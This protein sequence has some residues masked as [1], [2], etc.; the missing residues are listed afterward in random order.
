[1]E[2]FLEKYR[3]NPSV[4]EKGDT[5]KASRAQLDEKL[6]EKR[7]ESGSQ[8][9]AIPWIEK[10]RPKRIEDIVQQ[11]EVV[12]VLRKCLHGRDFPNLLF[13]GPP[14]T[15]KTST[16]LALA[17]QMFGDLFHDRVL[18]LNASDERGIQVIREKVKK[19]AHQI[20]GG[21]RKDGTQCPPFKLIIL[22]EADSMT[23][24][25]QAALRRTMEKEA[26]STRFCII[27]NYIS[28][29]IEPIASRCS[30]F[31]FKSLDSELVV[32]KLRSICQA[33]NVLLEDDLVLEEIVKMSEGDMRKAVTM[34]HTA[35]RWVGVGNE[36]TTADVSEIAAVIPMT[37]IEKV[38]EACKDQSYEKLE[39]TITSIIKEGYSA[40][41]FFNQLHDWI[42][43]DTTLLNDNK[44]AVLC[45]A[46]A[47]A[48]Y[49]LINGANEYLQMLYISSVLLQ[50]LS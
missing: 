15:G 10:Y 24:Q 50:Q 49:Q 33:E 19:F 6:V 13:Y 32:E 46:I 3:K 43:E 22:D 29:I 14:G 7:D 20:V 16:I 35:F 11:E 9:T 2:K 40:I 21:K 27:C 18:E 41:R 42:L 38:I 39:E 28:R 45:E 34:L 8:Q 12:S 47:E 44:K 4:K 17:K 30:K 26:A 37:K 48:D 36:L 5:Q 31:R 23:H 1:M 25:A